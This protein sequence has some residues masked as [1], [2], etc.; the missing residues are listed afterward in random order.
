MK[1]ITDEFLK[2][3]ATKADVLMVI[4]LLLKVIANTM[5]DTHPAKTALVEN[6]KQ[7][8]QRIVD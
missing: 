3:P 6:V 7:I 2:A 1:A 4:D 8:K 5:S